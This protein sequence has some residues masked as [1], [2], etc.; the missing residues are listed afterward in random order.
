MYPY[1]N[2]YDSFQSKSIHK[3]VRQKRPMFKSK[4]TH[5]IVC[6]KHLYMYSYINTY[7]SFQ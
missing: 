2:S 5:I 7:D 1:R 3:S 6:D 4:E